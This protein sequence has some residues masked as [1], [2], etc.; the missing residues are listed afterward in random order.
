VASDSAATILVVDDEPAARRVVSRVLR[1]AGHRV[2]EA[3]SGAAALEL[4]V[5]ERPD[6]VTLDVGLPDIDGFEVCRR[7]KEG[8]LTASIPV[9]HVSATYRDLEHRVK[10]LVGGADAYLAMPV[11]PRELEATVQALLRARGAEQA[12]RE[13]E[14][15][16]RTLVESM[17]DVV[18]VLDASQRYVG[19]HGRWLAKYGVNSRSVLGRTVRDV[20][21]ARQATVHEEANR[22]VLQGESLVYESSLESAEGIRYFET[23]LSPL[24]DASGGITGAVGVARDVTPWKRIQ[25][26]TTVQLGVTRILAE[27]PTMA[28]ALLELARVV[29]DGFGW[30]VG[31]AW[32][33]D[34]A[35]GVLRRV[36]GAT[37]PGT[38]AVTPTAARWSLTFAPGQGLAGRAWQS[39]DVTW[40]TDVAGEP[41]VADLATALRLRAAVAVPVRTLDATVA[42]MVFAFRVG[43]R[44]DDDLLGT[45]RDIGRRMGLLVEHKRVEQ[46]RRASDTR[47]RRVAESKMIGLAFWDLQGRIL[48]ANDAFLALIGYSRDEVVAGRVN[49][50]DLTPA[51]YAEADERAL[52]ELRRTGTCTP[53]EKEYVG[54]DGSRIPVLLGGGLLDETRGEGIA[55]AIDLTRRRAAER[56]RDALLASERAAR[57]EAESANRAKDVF[58]AVLSH[59]LRTPLQ[60]TL[61]WTR[62]L[63]S[64][65]LDALQVTRAVQNIERSAEAQ[66]QLIED[67][68]DVSRIVAGR[69]QLTVE[70][71]ALAE[72]VQAALEALRPAADEAGIALETRM[73]SS[74]SVMGDRIRLQQVVS[75]LA[76]NAIKFTPGGGRVEVRLAGV[77]S[78]AVLEVEDSGR[79]IAADALERVFHPFLQVDP[80]ASR[81]GGG[82]GL[83]LTIVR[84][85]AQLHG[86][87]VQAASDGEGRGAT[88]TVRLPLASPP[89]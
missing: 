86:G 10:G 16:F 31:E 13:S 26:Q 79:G 6:L 4:A 35:T 77:D 61:G 44:V 78:H 34:E 2:I 64:G 68:V 83:G 85:I 82:L 74:V 49:W 67:L 28:A 48:E 17:D 32:Q 14:Q 76:G 11:E 23:S 87:H 70:R 45:L 43:R 69:L 56:Q 3:A 1:Q 36:V 8:S 57:A 21:G 80:G 24:R 15:R 41:I 5:A 37:A 89:A 12:L 9:L 42:V 88:F 65:R 59:E 27:A 22:R 18:F 30:D 84:E 52:A 55:F 75:N 39:G 62:L 58:L 60:S 51:E 63:R 73:D 25:Q 81:P 20:L 66:M 7:L 40:T 72:V 46:A 33:V 71:M 53:F 50:R 29:A 54:K 47:F 19:L 38:T